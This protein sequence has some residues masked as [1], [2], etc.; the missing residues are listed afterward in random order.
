K[1][2]VAEI[3]AYQKVIDGARA[4]LDHYRPHIPINPEWP[5]ITVAE[6]IDGS[7]KNGYSGKPVQHETNLKV[8][9]L[10]AT[11]SGR[12]DLTQFKYLDEQLPADA[13][14]RCRK[15]DIYL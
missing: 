13:A 15:G 7:P 12:M 10:T 4:V 9:S 5:M 2:I 1:E 14:C 8:L 3:D 11:T 6:V